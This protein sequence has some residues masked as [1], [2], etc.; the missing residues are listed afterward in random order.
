MALEIWNGRMEGRV[1]VFSEGTR[2][3]GIR[4]KLEIPDRTR[5]LETNPKFELTLTPILDF[6]ESW[7][8]FLTQL[9]KRLAASNEPCW[10]LD[11]VEY[12]LLSW[13]RKESL[14]G[15]LTL[16]SILETI[17]DLVHEV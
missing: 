1:C 15:L 5:K 10:F 13:E 4:Y 2:A 9:R 8:T 12:V 16:K 3:Y 11:R 7:D 14:D 17:W 6:S